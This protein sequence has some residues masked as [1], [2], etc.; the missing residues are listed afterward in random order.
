MWLATFIRCTILLPDFNEQK[1]NIPR[2]AVAEFSKIF[3]VL[4]FR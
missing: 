1:K 2:K 4:P 3:R